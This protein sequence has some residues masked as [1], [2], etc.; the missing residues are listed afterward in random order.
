MQLRW[1]T[2]VI[3]FTDLLFYTYMYVW[4]LGYTKWEYWFLTITKGVQIH[5]LSQ[6][7]CVSVSEPIIVGPLY[8]WLM[9]K[10]K[11]LPI[12]NQFFPLLLTFLIWNVVL[13]FLQLQFHFQSF[14]FY[15]NLIKFFFFFNEKE[16][17]SMFPG[18]QCLR[19]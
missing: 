16:W 17:K 10:K 4:N 6:S 18:S 19:Q 8:P 15:R 13:Y 14:C 9:H 12:A 11:V 2:W 7:L 1:P 3:I 5:E